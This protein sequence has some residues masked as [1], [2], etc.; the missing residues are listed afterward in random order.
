M[1]AANAATP[2]NISNFFRITFN[3]TP[4][5]RHH[6]PAHNYDT[7]KLTMTSMLVRVGCMPLLG[8][9]RLANLTLPVL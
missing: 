5:A 4:N 1:T 7:G 9:A 8:A 3:K 2:P 6:P